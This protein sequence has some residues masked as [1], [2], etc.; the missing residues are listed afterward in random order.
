LPLNGA[1]GLSCWILLS[2]FVQNADTTPGSIRVKYCANCHACYANEVNSCPVDNSVLHKSS[3]LVQGMIIRNKY[4]ILKKIGTGG[5]ASVYLARHIAFDELRAI[6]VVRSWMAEDEGFLTRLRSEAVMLRRLQHPNAVRVDDI[7][8]SEDGRPFIVMEFVEGADLHAVIRE[9]GP[10]STTRVVSLARQVAAALAAAHKIGIIHRDVKP[11]NILLV[12]QNDGSEF[13]KV[14][15]FGIAK[16]RGST[17]E[18]PGMTQAGMVLCTPEYASP[19]QARGLGSDR[20]DGRT[21]LYSLGLVM[22]EMLTGEL[23]FQPDT[24]M[25]ILLAQIN[26]PPRPPTELKPELKISSAMSNFLMKALE[27]DPDQRFQSAEEMM[28]A[29]SKID[30]SAAQRTPDSG[31]A[32]MRSWSEGALSKIRLGADASS[33]ES[34]AATSATPSVTPSAFAKNPRKG[35]DTSQD[36]LPDIDEPRSGSHHPRMWAVAAVLVLASAGATMYVRWR[37]SAASTQSVVARPNDVDI[38]GGVKEKLVEID[39]GQKIRASVNKGVVHLEGEVASQPIVDEAVLSVSAVPGVVEVNKSGVR[40]VESHSSGTSV[41]AASATPAQPPL[42]VPQ[43]G[44]TATSSPAPVI[45][46]TRT[47]EENG[48]RAGRSSES[49]SSGRARELLEQAQ[50]AMDA[51]EYNDAITSYEAVLNMDHGNAGARNGMRKAEHAREYE[52]QLDSQK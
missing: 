47:H 38:L 24:P 21:D 2:L 51:G 28:E 1:R 52:E 10:M 41:T 5:M 36:L 6:K 26:T 16:L 39:G 31:Q 35:A 40:V 20:L 22:Y 32:R 9:Q 13:V 12:K 37:P 50:K 27:K 25:G 42:V 18:G 7:D 44:K 49:N 14:L 29:M 23:P 17:A 15:D 33:A 30:G 46:K 43:P 4:E 3:D 19:E 34:W 45:S 11:D 8:N 48:A